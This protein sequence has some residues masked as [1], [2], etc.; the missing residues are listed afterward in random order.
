MYFSVHNSLVCRQKH[1]NHTCEGLFFITL[2]VIWLQLIVNKSR[3]LVCAKFYKA[4]FQVSTRCINTIANTGERDKDRRG[5]NRVSNEFRL[6]QVAVEKF[7][8]ELKVNESHYNRAKSKRIYL[9]RE[10]NIKKLHTVYNDSA[11]A[12]LRISILQKVL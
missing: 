7:I 3:K 11:L 5:S 2:C 8:S 12:E 9:S 10:L 4:L 6:K 1:N